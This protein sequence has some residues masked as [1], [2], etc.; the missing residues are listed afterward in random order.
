M[1][2]LVDFIDSSDFNLRVACLCIVLAPTI[3]NLL[4]RLEYHTH[5]LTKLACGNRYLGCYILALWIFFFSLFRD[6]MFVSSSSSFLC[7][8]QF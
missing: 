5:L 7:V 3:W 4:A 8:F 6:Y 1:G 2:S